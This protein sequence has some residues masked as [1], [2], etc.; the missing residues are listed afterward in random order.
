MILAYILIRTFPPKDYN[1]IS[2]MVGVFSIVVA[3]SK[4]VAL[5]RLFQS[6]KKITLVFFLYIT[7]K[8][9]DEESRDN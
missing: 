5:I 6:F 1:K 2:V 3:E 8:S 9:F 7:K 4:F